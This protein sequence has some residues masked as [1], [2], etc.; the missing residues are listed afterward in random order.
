MRLAQVHLALVRKEDEQAVASPFRSKPRSYLGSPLGHGLSLEHAPAVLVGLAFFFYAVTGSH[1]PGAPSLSSL[2]K[3][4]P[5]D[6]ALLDVETFVPTGPEASASETGPERRPKEGIDPAVFESGGAADALSPAS[7]SPPVL[8]SAE[9]DG[10]RAAR[11]SPSGQTAG[12]APHA[13][14]HGSKGQERRLKPRGPRLKGLVSRGSHADRR[15]VS[16]SPARLQPE[17]SQSRAKPAGRAGHASVDPGNSGR[18]HRA[19]GRGPRP[20]HVVQG[21]GR[22]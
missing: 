11:P 1:G 22:H 20:D 16:Q 5:A 6:K 2:P 10:A 14:S 15:V 9:S 17:R 21:R 18:Q 13:K 3:P 12:T 8:V 7:T 19:K 4:L